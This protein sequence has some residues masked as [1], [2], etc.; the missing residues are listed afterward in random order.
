MNTDKIYTSRVG[1]AQTFKEWEHEAT[2]FYNS[3]GIKRPKD[4]WPKWQNRLG[5][6]ESSPV[7]R[8]CNFAKEN[9]DWSWELS[10]V[11]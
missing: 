1:K 6:L 11:E 9:R 10:G 7:Y 8:P 3:L 2:L 4:W 5:M